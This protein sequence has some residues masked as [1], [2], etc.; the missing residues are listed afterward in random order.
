MAAPWSNLGH[1]R[2]GNLTRPVLKTTQFLIWPEGQKKVQS[3]NLPGSP[4]SY[5]QAG[6]LTIPKTTCYLFVLFSLQ[7]VTFKLLNHCFEEARGFDVKAPFARRLVSRIIKPGEMTKEF[8][9]TA[10]QLHGTFID[11][12]L[13]TA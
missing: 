6:N 13:K 5:I 8:W 4:A 2:G 3:G 11:W 10:I 12:K 7:F 9:E 1:W